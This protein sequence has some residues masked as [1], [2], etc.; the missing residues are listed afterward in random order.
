[1]DAFSSALSGLSAA[2]TGLA[3]TANN[4]ANVQS[5]GFKAKRVNLAS[6]ANGGVAVQGLSEDPTPTV[7]GGSNVDLATEAVQ[8]MSLD[9]MYR[10]NLKVIQAEDQRMK[11]TLDLKA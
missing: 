4:V 7:L 10:A 3:V 1:M 5:D 2:S 8:G 6:Q 9:L 11:A